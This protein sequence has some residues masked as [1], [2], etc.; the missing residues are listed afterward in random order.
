[1]HLTLSLKHDDHNDGEQDDGHGEAPDV[2]A[3]LEAGVFGSAEVVPVQK[4]R[5]LTFLY[6]QPIPMKLFV[7]KFSRQTTIATEFYHKFLVRG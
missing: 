6:I 7:L 2:E 5:V 3:A 1:M 4:G